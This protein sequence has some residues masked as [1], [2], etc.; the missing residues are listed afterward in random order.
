MKRSLLTS[1]AV[2]SAAGLSAAAA[3]LL[4]RLLR[5]G[6]V[7]RAVKVRTRDTSAGNLPVTP[8]PANTVTATAMETSDLD[9]DSGFDSG[10]DAGFDAEA[11][12][13]GAG[14]PDGAGG[15]GGAGDAGGPGGAGSAGNAGTAKPAR[16]WVVD[17]SSDWD[18]SPLEMVIPPPLGGQQRPGPGPAPA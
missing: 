5:H 18:G 12:A 6:A 8:V 14:G 17:N 1:A 10:F 7:D 13:E 16:T 2:L 9:F 11:E 4:H 15:P 3:A